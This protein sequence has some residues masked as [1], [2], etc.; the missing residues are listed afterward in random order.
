VLIRPLLFPARAILQTPEAAGL[1]CADV[2]IHTE[3]RRRY[4]GVGERQKRH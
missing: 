1:A 4:G 2:T 3:D